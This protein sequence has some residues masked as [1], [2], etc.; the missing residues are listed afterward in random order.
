MSFRG[1]PRVGPEARLGTGYGG[2]RNLDQDE[3][4]RVRRPSSARPQ[5]RLERP[6]DLLDAEALDDVAG[7]H[8]LVVLE[9]HAAFLAGRDLAHLVL[10]ALQRLELAF[11]DDDVVAEQADIGAALDDAFGDPAAGDLADL[12]DLEDLQDLGVAEEGLAPLGR[13]HAR[14]RRLHIVDEVVDDVVVADLD[15]VGLRQRCAPARWR[16]R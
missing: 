13:E 11:V 15:A 7:A 6:R 12:R 1:H 10:E 16:G 5:P 8:V 14:H 4:P 3:G 2:T 9:G